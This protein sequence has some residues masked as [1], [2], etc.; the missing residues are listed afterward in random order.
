MGYPMTYGR[1]I[2][3]NYL[4]GEYEQGATQGDLRRLETDQRDE[5]HLGLYALHVGITPEQVKQVLDLFFGAWIGNGISNSVLYSKPSAYT[6]EAWATAYAEL[7]DKTR[8]AIEREKWAEYERNRRK[9]D[10]AEAI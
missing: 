7:W 4:Q 1:V 3:R 8:G 6:K 5:Y 10:D 9:A 2:N